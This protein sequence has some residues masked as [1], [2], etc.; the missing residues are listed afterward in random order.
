MPMR[1][2]AVL[3]S[4]A[5]LAACAGPSPPS[6]TPDSASSPEAQPPTPPDKVA[7][8]FAAYQRACA[9]CHEEGLDGAPATGRAEDWSGRS[10]LWQAVLVEHAKL[11]YFDMPARGG[12]T[13]LSDED[14]QAAAEYMLTLTHPQAPAG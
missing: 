1:W 10:W 11:G 5:M 6:G 2:V 3:A 9:A 13:T 14:V 7:A 8:G 4:A 12:D